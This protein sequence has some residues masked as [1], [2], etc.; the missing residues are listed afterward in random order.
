M[1]LSVLV[2][3]HQKI[4]L[5]ASVKGLSEK[6]IA[7]WKTEYHVVNALKRLKHDTKLSRNLVL[8]L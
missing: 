4:E 7:P 3:T 2:L 8:A 6:E 1:K 5:P